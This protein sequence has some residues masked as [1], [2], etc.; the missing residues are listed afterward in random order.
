MTASK[1]LPNILKNLPSKRTIWRRGD[2][3]DLLTKCAAKEKVRAKIFRSSFNS[4]HVAEKWKY[5]PDLPG[6]TNHIWPSLA[7]QQSFCAN[8][9]NSLKTHTL[10]LNFIPWRWPFDR[11]KPAANVSRWWW[12]ESKFQLVRNTHL[13][14]GSEA[15]YN[16]ALTTLRGCL[17][18]IM[19]HSLA[20]PDKVANLAMRNTGND[21]NQ[22][23]ANFHHDKY[24]TVQELKTQKR[25]HGQRVA[26]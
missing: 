6:Q 24:S 22:L 21:A 14:T 9:L 13:N 4:Q 3:D 25:Q 5:S 16:S 17:C 18:L 20:L 10:S 8:S 11:L 7:P 15:Y 2:N 26:D 1:K 23:N 12:W 19:H